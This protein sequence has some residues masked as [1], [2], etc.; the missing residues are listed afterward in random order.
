MQ[1]DIVSEH[2]GLPVED[3]T[4][5]AYLARPTA[6]GRYPGVIVGFEMFGLTS[7]IRNMTERIAQLGY[8]AIAPDFYHR[9]APGIE[10][11]AS[12]EGRS[13][14]FE[15][16]EQVTRPGVLSDLRAAITYL[17][18][19]MGTSPKTGMVGFSFGG[20]I[21]YFAATQLDLAATAAF[22]P[23]WLPTTDIALS[24]PEP[25]LSLAPGI[26]KHDGRLLIL[27][28]DQDH[29]VSADQTRRIGEELSA[30][31]VRHELVV[32][33]GTPHGFACDERDTFRP[34]VAEDAWRRVGALLAAEL[35]AG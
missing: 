8:V 3:G 11:A 20:H 26:A 9:V 6:P 34:A 5:G 13:R 24:R 7:Y 18:D 28:G 33:P 15:L 17:R 27:V 35:S 1:Y 25:T 29:A 14:G 19:S 12:P 32:Y 23:G 21:A 2:L 10:L 30:A 4:M 16:L 22:Y 31:D